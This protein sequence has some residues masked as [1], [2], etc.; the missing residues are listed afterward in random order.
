MCLFRSPSLE[1]FAMFLSV[2]VLKSKEPEAKPKPWAG[3]LKA[4]GAISAAISFL[5]VLNQVTGVVQ[6]FRI[7]HRE[8]REAMQAGEQAE[9]RGDYQAAFNSFKHALDLD[10]IDRRAQERQTEAA[11]L[12]LEDFDPTPQDPAPNQ[13]VTD[14]ANLALPVFDK[15]LVGAR[16]P[17]AADILAHV[18]WAN[19]LRY[20]EG[21]KEGVTVEENFRQALERDPNNVYGH[22]MW[23]FWILWRGGELDAANQHFSAAV[24]S[25]RKKEYARDLQLAALSYRHDNE[26]DA[27]ELRVA[28]EMR[29]NGEPVSDRQCHDI[30]DDTIGERLGMHNKL[31]VI[32][33]VLPAKETQATFDWLN[34]GKITSTNEKQAYSPFIAANL[35]EIAGDRE[36]ALTIYRALQ[37]DPRTKS[38]LLVGAVDDGI[39]R[40]SA[41]KSN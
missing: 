6:E 15:G 22:A 38:L 4:A 26:T 28:N 36:G 14:T 33:S 40:L 31:A 27:E 7:H 5:L 8:F 24:A 13:S 20:R 41:G 16:G 2:H 1:V 17:A 12:W 29:K 21:V 9:N 32:L 18:G 37:K 23:G 10:P 35:L 3:P 30:L 11:M 19:F 34:A 25:G 39:K